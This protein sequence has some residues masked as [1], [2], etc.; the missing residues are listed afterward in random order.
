[1]EGSCSNELDLKD[2]VHSR[3]GADTKGLI[4]RIEL[5]RIDCL[6]STRCFVNI[7]NFHMT[8]RGSQPLTLQNLRLREVK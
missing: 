7:L 5:T 2:N 8:L 3:G 1:M 6:Q 4:Q